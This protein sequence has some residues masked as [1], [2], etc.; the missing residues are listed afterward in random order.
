M[1][2]AAKVF[3]MASALLGF[4]YALQLI[5]GAPAPKKKLDRTYHVESVG[6]MASQ[7]PSHWSAKFGTHV[8]VTGWLTYKDHEADGDWHLRLCESAANTEME[9]S[10][11][12]VAECIPSLPCAVPA[13]G[14]CV[15]VR[16]ISRFDAEGWN[17]DSK[18]GSHG[19]WEAHP[20]EELEVVENQKCGGE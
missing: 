2:A 3:C 20:V 14:D 6:F 4:G 1:R 9:R 5:G 17:P 16:G 7:D 11:C 10:A 18:S 13:V 8:E 19:W 15:M 12:V